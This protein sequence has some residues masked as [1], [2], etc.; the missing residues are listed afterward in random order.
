MKF[1]RYSITSEASAATAGESA[2]ATT[3]ESA[4]ATA[5][6]SAA[7]ESAATAAVGHVYDFSLE[8][9]I[10]PLNDVIVVTCISADRRNSVESSLR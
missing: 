7:G 6:E 2:S 1:T 3:G 4:S 8:E 9:L 5:G 10:V